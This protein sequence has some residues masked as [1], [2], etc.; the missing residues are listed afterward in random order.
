MHLKIDKNLRYTIV[1]ALL[2]TIA[3][4]VFVMTIRT[5]VMPQMRAI[6][7]NIRAEKVFSHQ[8]KGGIGYQILT[9]SYTRKQKELQNQVTELKCGFDNVNELSDFIQIIYDAAWKQNSETIKFNKT[10][11]QPETP[12][13][14]VVLSPVIFEMTTSYA[15]LGRLVAFI[16][17][18]PHIARI[19]GIGI[20]AGKNNLI[21]AT[22]VVTAF[23]KPTAGGVH[24]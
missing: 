13:G 2:L 19:D 17:R 4:A 8:V 15:A 22:M 7:E 10:L 23:V 18:I 12:A 24:E 3:G 16:E 5:V 11:P 14:N 6:A 20:I 9:E 1:P 21:E